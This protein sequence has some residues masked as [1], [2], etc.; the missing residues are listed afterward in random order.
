VVEE[1]GTAK[2]E[3][4]VVLEEGDAHKS[5]DMMRDEEE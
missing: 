1:E 5:V 2:E 3:V 4:V